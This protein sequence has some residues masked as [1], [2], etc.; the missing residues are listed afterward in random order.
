[1]IFHRIKSE[2]TAHNSYLI[3]SGRDV[4]VI[5]PR[6]DCEVYL[7]LAKQHGV[8]Q[9]PFF[10]IEKDNGEIDIY[11]IYFQFVKEVLQAQI[12]PARK[13]A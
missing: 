9:A 13:V 4:A 1:M 8:E 6:R 10:L 11:T 7:E 5:D 3:G 2:G 12:S